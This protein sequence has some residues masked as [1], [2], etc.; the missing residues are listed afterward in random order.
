MNNSVWKKGF[1]IGIILLFFGVGVFSS[2]CG[3]VVTLNTDDNTVNNSTG[4]MT[5]IIVSLINDKKNTTKIFIHLT[6]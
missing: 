3:K 6:I 5:F 1:V 4:K 2:V